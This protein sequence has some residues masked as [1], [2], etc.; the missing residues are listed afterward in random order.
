[1]AT[2]DITAVSKLKHADLWKAAKRLGGQSALGRLLGVRPDQVG[3]WCNLQGVP[4]CEGEERDELERKLLMVTGKT[5]DE[6]FPS[7]LCAAEKFLKSKKIVESTKEIDLSGLIGYA[8][9]TQERLTLEAPNT[10]I[11]ELRE[12][13]K[14]LL[15]TLS[16]R[17]R[18]IIKL[19]YGLG[20][21]YCYSLE[22]VGRIFRVTRERVRQIEAKA[23]RKLQEPNRAAKLVDF[24][25]E[26]TVRFS[27]YEEPIEVWPSDKYSP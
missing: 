5:F 9:Q 25:P 6:L 14:N 11:D 12:Q 21:G 17:E 15:P 13:I 7:E 10:D 26:R 8:E 3:R 24:I 18:E 19:R 20:D 23:V 4:T 1:M 22:E 2:F 27:E 16:H